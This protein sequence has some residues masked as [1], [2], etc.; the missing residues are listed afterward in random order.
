MAQHDQAHNSGY[1]STFVLPLGL[2]PGETALQF[3]RPSSGVPHPH[4]LDDVLLPFDSVNDSTGP[5]N[6]LANAGVAKF[7]NDAAGFGEFGQATHRLEDLPHE[8][9]GVT[10]T[11]FGNIRGKFLEVEASGWGL[12]QLVS[13]SLNSSATRS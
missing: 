7:R 11:G 4:D 8:T 9:G 3:G 12:N 13:H 6:D 2:F 10:G 5:A 1:H